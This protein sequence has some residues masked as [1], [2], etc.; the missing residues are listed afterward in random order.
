MWRRRKDLVFIYLTQTPKA[1]IDKTG[2][3][4]T[5]E[6]LA[7][8]KAADAIILGAIGGPV[9]RPVRSVSVLPSS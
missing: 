6:A 3:A 2:S 7:A 1:S 8:A 4:L 9:S 5:D